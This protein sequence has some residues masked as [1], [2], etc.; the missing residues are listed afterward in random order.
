[1][2]V[3]VK[4]L[5][6]GRNFKR[7][8]VVELNQ[9]EY[10]IRFKYNNGT[11]ESVSKTFAEI[12][13][14]D[15]ELEMFNIVEIMKKENVGKQYIDNNKGWIWKVYCLDESDGVISLEYT[16]EEKLE[17]ISAA[18]AAIEDIFCLDTVLKMKFKEIK[19]Q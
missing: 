18:S 13:A 4:E 14:V 1:M 3:T 16:G 17:L 8:G 9:D 2:I 15:T 6:T 5:N 7:V 11:R 12:V 19:E 10:M